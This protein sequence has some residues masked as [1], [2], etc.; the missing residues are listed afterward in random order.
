MN[1]LEFQSQL[2]TA[3]RRGLEAQVREVRALGA[4]FDH[5]SCDLILTLR[6]GMTLLVPARLLQGVADASPEQIERVELAADGSALRFAELDADFLVQDIASGSFGT[7]KWMQ[8]LE[9]SGALDAASIERRRQVDELLLTSS[10]QS[11]GRKGGSARTGVKV[12]A[13]RANGAKG[14]RPRKTND[15]PKRA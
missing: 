10:A 5:A 9:D 11:M 15:E 3:N 13:S 8:H 4:R 14:G 7:R 12:A 2:E 6:G 1:E